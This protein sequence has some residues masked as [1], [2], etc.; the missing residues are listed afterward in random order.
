MFIITLRFSAN[1]SAAPEFMAAHN[2]WIAQGFADGVF[3]CVGSLKPAGGGAIIATDTSRDKIEARINADPFVA[4][5]VVN[6][7][8]IEVDVKK[9]T[10]AM[11]ALKG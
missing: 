11:D 4:E 6:A 5:D 9:A 2:E 1:A 3:H 8:I 10:P 7:E